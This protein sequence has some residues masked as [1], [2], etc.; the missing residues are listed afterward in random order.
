MNSGY[1]RQLSD[2]LPLCYNHFHKIIVLFWSTIYYII[3]TSSELISAILALLHCIW[4]CT[5]MP[6]FS[7]PGGYFKFWPPKGTSLH[8][9][10][11]FEPFCINIGWGVLAED[12]V[13]KSK[14]KLRNKKK[15]QKPYILHIYS[16]A[17]GGPITTS[18]RR[19]VVLTDVIPCF[20][21]LFDQLIRFAPTKAQSW[22]F[23]SV[24]SIGCY[25]VQ[26]YRGW[27]W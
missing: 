24:R 26:H 19:V 7:S 13:E 4:S 14:S 2:A 15:P 21:F 18:I 10:E 3:K 5:R 20:N 22:P 11:S 8:Y 27:T 17:M 25:N 12:D 6:I 23:C 1:L 16:H 9:M